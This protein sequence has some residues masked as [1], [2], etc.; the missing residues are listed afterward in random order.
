MVVEPLKL[1]PVGLAVS[2]A[3]RYVRESLELLAAPELE[4]TAALGVSELVTNAV[5]HGRTAIIVG[6]R[7]MPTG[8]VRVEVGDGSPAIPRQRRFDLA[9]TTGRGLRLV[10]SVSLDWGVEPWAPERG[11][12][13]VVWFEPRESV[14]AAGFADEDWAVDLEDL[15]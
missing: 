7:R 12:G 4:D 15:L 10:E 5:I 2:D 8:R 1:D 14:T 3:R 9:S 6:V 11:R 13:K